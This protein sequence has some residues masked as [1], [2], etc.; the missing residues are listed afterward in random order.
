MPQSPVIIVPGITATSLS[1]YYQTPP[2]RVWD[3]PS[4]ERMPLGFIRKFERICLH[5][6][7]MRF[8]LR[9][10]A[11]VKEVSVFSAVYG[12]LIEELRVNLEQDGKPTPVYPFGYDWRQSCA[13][14]AA[15][16]ERFIDEVM[17]RT[18]LLPHYRDKEFQVDLVAHSMGGLVAAD[19]LRRFGKKGKVRK[20]VSLGT[21]FQGSLDAVLKLIVGKGQLTGNSPRDRER[22]T[23]RMTPSL[24]ELLPSFPGAVQ[25]TESQL[26]QLF[27]PQAWQPS[28]VRTLQ[29]FIDEAQ[30]QA[31]AKELFAGMLNNARLF[32]GRL[33]KLKLENILPEGDASWLAVVGVGCDTQVSIANELDPKGDPRFEIL[34]DQDDWSEGDA[35]SPETGDG[36]VPFLG[37]LPQFMDKSR[38]VGVCPED[39]S[40]WELADRLLVET[41]GLHP[42]LPAVNLVQRLVTRHLKSS[43]QGEVWGWKPPTVSTE[44]WSPPEW[45]QRRFY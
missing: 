14:T 32:I 16:L 36:T 2:N 38:V 45:L 1:D 26:E 13:L 29:R 34:A 6:D 9:E 42:F 44:E 11:R 20:V 7:D 24:Y 37:A 35:E 23:A 25:S 30:S 27:K 17:Q 12:D 10:P 22:Q 40:R 21:P 39:L 33:A 8:E 43:Y 31:D 19:Y 28:L 3:L 4:L 5:P 18:A 15:E 41:Q